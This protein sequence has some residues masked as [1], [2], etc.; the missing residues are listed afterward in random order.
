MTAD[1]SAYFR[2]RA[3]Q[4][5]ESAM[6]SADPVVRTTHLELAEAYEARLAGAPAVGWVAAVGGRGTAR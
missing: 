3:Q 1:D 5:R 4:E 2:R 6:R